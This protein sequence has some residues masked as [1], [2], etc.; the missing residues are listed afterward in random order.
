MTKKEDLQKKL[1]EFQILDAN[2]KMLQERAEILNK[3]L[4]ELQKTGVAIEELKTTK[5]EKALIP[6]GS[7]NFVYGEIENCDEIIVGVG[8]G[9]A[10]KKKREEALKNLDS[11]IKEIEKDMNDIIKQSSAFVIQLEKVQQEI[12]KLQK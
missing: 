9:V 8:N 5:P 11:R 4:E 12:E 7:G 6:L 10:I 3:K 1:I 2:F